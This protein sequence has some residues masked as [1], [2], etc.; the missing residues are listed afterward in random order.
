MHGFLLEHHEHVCAEATELAL[1]TMS[2]RS[3]SLHLTDR[4]PS[5]PHARAMNANAEIRTYV[6]SVRKAEWINVLKINV[7]AHRDVDT[8]R[9][10]EDAF[11]MSSKTVRLLDFVLERGHLPHL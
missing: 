11:W 8:K 9:L 7:L 1:C 4:A 6:A 10:N 5:L 3:W 2:E